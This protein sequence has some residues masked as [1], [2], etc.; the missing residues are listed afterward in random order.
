MKVRGL[1]L[2]LLHL[3]TINCH[4]AYRSPENEDVLRKRLPNAIIIGVKKAG[5]RALLEYLKLNPDIRSPAPEIHFF[6]KYYFKGM[7]WYRYQMAPT[8]PWQIT[9]EKTPSYFVTKKAPSRIF[10]MNPLIKLILVVRN[11]VTRA[12]SDYTQ[13]IAKKPGLPPF[14]RMAFLTMSAPKSLLVN[15][16]WG[17]IKI[18]HYDKFMKQWLKYFPLQQIHIVDGQK[19]LTNPASEGRSVERFLGVKNPIIGV[20]NFVFRNS[21]HLSRPKPI[22][23]PCLLTII[24][25][26][27]RCL[28]KTKGRMHVEVTRKLKTI[29][30]DYFRSHN[31]QFFTS[32]GRRFDWEN[33]DY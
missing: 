14:H 15:S 22:N 6:D 25:P 32:I 31:E 10:S 27:P 24:N 13:N 8:W 21:S 17:A 26:I 11:P 2:L 9:I 7:E 1:L 29:L 16:S 23:F 18:G 28:G 30:R 3:T 20:N 33:M 4:L 19:L 12:I 5:T